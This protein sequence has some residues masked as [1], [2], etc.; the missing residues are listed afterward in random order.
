MSGAGL[1]E[2]TILQRLVRTLRFAPSF[3][4]G[5]TPENQIEQLKMAGCERIY[6]ENASV[7][8]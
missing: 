5:S 7:V 8:R 3:S 1:A 2:F 4:R 6:K